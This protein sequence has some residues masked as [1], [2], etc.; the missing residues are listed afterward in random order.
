MPE[1]FLMRFTVQ[2]RTT[3]PDVSYSINPSSLAYG[4]NFDRVQ[5]NNGNP[6]AVTNVATLIS[7]SVGFQQANQITT[8][9]LQLGTGCYFLDSDC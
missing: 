1:T 3:I 6:I 8:A 2:I 5:V 7:E 4:V 9:A